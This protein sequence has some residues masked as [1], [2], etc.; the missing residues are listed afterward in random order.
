MTN[1]RVDDDIPDVDVDDEYIKRTRRRNRVICSRHLH[2]ISLGLITE[3][4]ID[5]HQMA[6]VW[7]AVIH[8][9]FSALFISVAFLVVAVVTVF[10]VVVV[11]VVAAASVMAVDEIRPR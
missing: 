8:V 2:Q 6:V 11:I 9:I 5:D 10:V 7:L 1:Q 3:I 4:I